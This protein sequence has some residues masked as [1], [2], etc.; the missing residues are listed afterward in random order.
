MLREHSQR[1]TLRSGPG[2][3][4]TVADIV[5]AAA[6]DRRPIGETNGYGHRNDSMI[7]IYNTP[8]EKER[9]AGLPESE[10]T[11]IDV[12]DNKIYTLIW[13]EPGHSINGGRY[14]WREAL[15]FP[16]NPPHSA[17]G[18]NKRTKS[19]RKRRCKK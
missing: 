12:L 8:G 13:F 18:R 7:R 4:F 11:F 16:H 2:L 6:A 19:T 1:D 14:E 17:G 3:P 9:Y 15:S 10:R 5:S